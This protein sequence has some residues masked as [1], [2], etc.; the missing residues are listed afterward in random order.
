MTGVGWHGILSRRPRGATNELGIPFRPKSL[1][2]VTD[3][4][5]GNCQ[6]HRRHACRCTTFLSVG[7]DCKACVKWRVGGGDYSIIVIIYLNIYIYIYGIIPIW[8]YMYYIYNIIIMRR[9]SRDLRCD[10]T[11]YSGHPSDETDV[12]ERV[13]S[14]GDGA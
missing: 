7:H 9:G 14:C 3:A 4:D 11:G 13:A 6:R 12:C 5:L 2:R 10:F 1:V 8:I